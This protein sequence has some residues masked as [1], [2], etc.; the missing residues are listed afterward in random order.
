MTCAT[1]ASATA[2]ML[3]NALLQ[4]VQ[5]ACPGSGGGVCDQSAAG[6]N[7]TNCTQCLQMA[8]S[9][10]GQCANQQQACALD[11][12]GGGVGGTCPAGQT[13]CGGTCTDTTSDTSNCGA[14]GNACAPGQTCTAG[15]CAAG[16]GGGGGVGACGNGQTSC[17]G[18]CTDLT[19]DSMNCGACGH[20]CTRG[21]ICQAGQC[22][23]GG[24]GG[25]AAGMTGCS[26]AIT[27][28]NA[29]NSGDQ[30]CENACIANTTTQGQTL[31]QTLGQC[32][33]TACPSTNGDVCDSTSFT[34]DP[35]ACDS[36]YQ[37]AQ[38][39]GG[40]CDSSLQ[41]CLANGP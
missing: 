20:A 10:G 28:L 21:R 11:M 32:L 22:T 39:T 41:A 19:S 24:G 14:C 34:F 29:C 38:A 16:G 15:A 18:V 31:L 17:G 5:M 3:L 8:Q 9:T 1:N 4:C 30:T 26:G 27:C 12:G 40:S 13:T 33:E 35:T 25:G 37:S 6:F 36:C 7:Q 23:L 2:Q